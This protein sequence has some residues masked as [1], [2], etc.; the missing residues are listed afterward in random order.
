MMSFLLYEASPLSVTPRIQQPVPMM[1]QPVPMMQQPMPMMQQ[2]IQNT[3]QNQNISKV[4]DSKSISSQQKP[5]RTLSD[6]AKMFGGAGLFI[7]GTALA[8]DLYTN[9][10]PTIGT[11][12]L[13]GNMSNTQTSQPNEE[14]KTD[15]TLKETHKPTPK[16]TPQKNPEQPQMSKPSITTH[17]PPVAREPRVFVAQ[18]PST[19]RDPAIMVDPKT[20]NVYTYEWNNGQPISTAYR[21][22]NRVPGSFITRQQQL[23]KM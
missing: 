16:P 4:D 22:G 9:G 6:Y 15:E 1:Q 8:H 11:G 5:S 3:S 23:E 7:G 20:G 18:H 14:T 12:A 19:N 2:P 17:Y 21:Y 10:L 13:M